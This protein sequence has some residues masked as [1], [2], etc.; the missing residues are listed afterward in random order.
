MDWVEGIVSC[1]CWGKPKLE[2]KDVELIS[3]IYDTSLDPDV[4]PE[5][6]L[7]LAH[8]LGAAGCFIFE[9]MLTSDGSQI[10]SRLFSENYDRGIVR[11]YLVKFNEQEISDQARFAELSAQQNS[12]ELISDIHLRPKVSDLL[13]QPN[14]KFMMQAGLKHR[15]GALLNKDLFYVDRFALQFSADHGPI[16]EKERKEANLFLPHVA[17]VIGLARPLEERFQT[18]NVLSSMLDT[19]DQGIAILGPRGAIQFQNS[20]FKRIVEEHDFFEVDASGYLR[21]LK[22]NQQSSYHNLIASEHAHGQFG[23]RARRE[24]LVHDL[25]EEGTA[26]FIEI[27]PVSNGTHT[28]KLDAG[29]RLLTV[30]DTSRQI[31]FDLDRIQAFF[32]LS[33][34]ETEILGLI[35]NGL[36]NNEVADQRNRSPDTIK[37]QITALMRKTNSRNRTELVHMVRNLSSPIRYE[38]PAGR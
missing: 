37:S 11:D 27:C 19:A 6:L 34:A 8:R 29:S 17:K 23:A 35:A 9:E 33:K 21:C 12:V 25:A 24:A 20:T 15:A 28:G 18:S 10:A 26:L 5:V 2:S 30:I 38:V 13:E 4:W 32:L 3:A 7:R 36:S 22:E 1:V 31:F 14:T 16:T